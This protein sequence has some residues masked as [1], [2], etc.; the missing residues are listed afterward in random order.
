MITPF[1]VWT[2]LN[3]AGHMNLHHP[4]LELHKKF[5]FLTMWSS[6]TSLPILWIVKK[7]KPLPDIMEEEWFMNMV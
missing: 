5:A 2:G 4:I 7:Q 3:E 6:L 1:I